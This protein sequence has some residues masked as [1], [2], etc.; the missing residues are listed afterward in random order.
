MGSVGDVDDVDDNRAR[1]IESLFDAAAALPAA[2]RRPYLERACADDPSLVESVLG[3][4]AQMDQTGPGVRRPDHRD[5]SSSVGRYRITEP[6]RSGGQG[7]VFLATDNELP[8]TVLA[9]KVVPLHPLDVQRR[10]RFEIEVKALTSM[11]HDNIVRVHGV[12]VGADGTGFIA[13]ELVRDATAITAY[14][15]AAGLSMAQ[16]LA[17]VRQICAG[18]QHAHAKGHIHRD[19]KPGNLLVETIDGAP[20]VRI[21]D[22]GVCKPAAG[23]PAPHADV[24]RVE[25][26]VGT[27]RYMSPEQADGA[28]IDA[29]SDVYA[30]GVVL[31]ELIAGETPF[32]EELAEA[33]SASAIR[34]V[35]CHRT[36]EPPSARA[37]R[38]GRV[39]LANRARGDLDRIVMKCLAKEREERYRSVLDLDAELDR[40]ERGMPI[41]ARGRSPLYAARKFVRRN[42]A[43]VS[44]TGLALAASV[45]ALAFWLH[46]RSVA[47]QAQSELETSKV[48]SLTEMFQGLNSAGVASGVRER[49][50]ADIRRLIDRSSGSPA[51]LGLMRSQLESTLDRANVVGHVRDEFAHS[52]V[53]PSALGIIN[54][55]ELRAETLVDRLR[56]HLE[57]LDAFGAHAEVVKLLEPLLVRMERELGPDAMPT[58]QVVSDLGAASFSAD[59]NVAK[60]VPLF[61]RAFEGRRNA[62]GPEHELTVETQ[63]SLLEAL[64]ASG[65]RDAVA[66]CREQ[67]ERHVRSAF[68]ESDDRRVKVLSNIAISYF[69]EGG[70]TAIANCKRLLDEAATLAQAIGPSTSNKRS[71]LPVKINLAVMLGET[72]DPGRA[73]EL[74]ERTIEECESA[75]GARDELTIRAI[76]EL[77]TVLGRVRR[78][79]EAIVVAE[80]ALRRAEEE[81]GPAHNLTSLVRGRL[82]VAYMRDQRHSDAIPLLRATIAHRLALAPPD[83][84]ETLTMTRHLAV[85][86][87][88]DGECAEAIDLLSGIVAFGRRTTP[89]ERVLQRMSLGALGTAFGRDDRFDEAMAVVEESWVLALID[90]KE[91]GKETVDAALGQVAGVLTHW[92][93]HAPGPA[94]AEARDRLRRMELLGP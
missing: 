89:T 54:E 75:L 52:I 92:E 33:R 24:T 35:L 81:F 60:A 57:A 18:M 94:A 34:A 10:Q 69:T 83:D 9:L 44:G 50:M 79:A 45:A 40:L 12:G 87:R 80:R 43:A 31:Y 29:L 53:V 32:H 58:L 30:I 21:I 23:T 93:L 19:L 49:L 20:R 73:I 59:G 1:R 65:D 28:D 90:R 77:G 22:F 47:A 91:T 7:S 46:T 71:I 38:R 5:A 17:L 56:P 78:H 55:S 37:M 88:D 64:R 61:R 74:L 72:G 6:L 8:D 36:P 68:P 82:A 27:P 16:R 4:L 41:A 84:H 86:L 66:A 39:H 67:L 63:A 25:Q 62:L 11:R 48:R 42:W 26:L 51:E 15:D 14:A 76:N 2:E 3:M 70:K 85:E 13:M